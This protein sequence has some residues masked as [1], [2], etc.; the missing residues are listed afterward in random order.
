M[1]TTILW[2]KVVSLNAFKDLAAVVQTV[3]M[4]QSLDSRSTFYI[5][6]VI[7]SAYAMLWAA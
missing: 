2:L 3:K 7:L 4:A 5:A 6:Y 1:H